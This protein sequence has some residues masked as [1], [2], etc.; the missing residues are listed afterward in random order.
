VGD[1]SKHREWDEAVQL[2]RISKNNDKSEIIDWLR[3]YHDPFENPDLA[4]LADLLD[5]KQKRK[6]GGQKE[7]KIIS[8]LK[9]ARASNTISEL[10]AVENITLEVAVEKAA[11]SLAE[12]ARKKGDKPPKLSESTLKK[13]YLKNKKTTINPPKTSA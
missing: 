5:D 9:Q 1:D 2:F 4:F 10:M 3:K 12:M 7:G 13:K 11:D 6:R 8:G